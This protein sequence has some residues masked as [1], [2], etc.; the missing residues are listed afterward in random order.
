MKQVDEKYVIVGKIGATYGIQ[1]WLK[2]HSFTDVKADIIDYEPW[3]IEEGANWKKVKVDGAREHGKGVVAK[4]AG[5]NNPEQARL[6]TG[7][8]IAI[9]RT[10]LPVLTKGEYYWNDLIGLTVIDQHNNTLGTVIY[11]LETGSNDVL[12]V[13]GVIELGIPF[14]VGDVIKQVDLVN[15]VIHVDW[16]VI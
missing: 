16:E 6:L 7:K 10:Q 8:E 3:Y 15:R 13:K 12:V 1:G 4:L 2:I 9:L 14:L 11:L 5:W